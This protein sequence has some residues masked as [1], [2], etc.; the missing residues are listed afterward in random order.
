MNRIA[1]KG[2]GPLTA[3]IA[4]M[5]IAVDS[6]LLRGQRDGSEMVFEAPVPAGTEPVSG[7][8]GV[9]P[10]P[11][12]PQ[13]TNSTTGFAPQKK[14]MSG[15][16]G[17]A[18]AGGTVKTSVKQ[19]G[20][21]TAPRTPSTGRNATGI[22]QVSG[23]L[24]SPRTAIPGTEPKRLIPATTI[25]AAP[26]PTVPSAPPGM[27]SNSFVPSNQSGHVVPVQAT[28]GIGSGVM[29]AGNRDPLQV[30]TPD[31][32]DPA[33]RRNRREPAFQPIQMTPTDRGV[34]PPFRGSITGLNFGET[35]VERLIQMQTSMREMEQQ[36]DELRQLNAGLQ[37]RIKERE[38]QMLAAVRE[39]KVARKELALAKTDLERSKKELQNL[40]DRV[41]TAERE[42]AAV[43]RSMGPLLQQLLE[44]D[45][46]SSMPPNPAE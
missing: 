40:Q 25:N 34:Q 12:L 8:R 36:N 38:E 21:G 45:D 26:I 42:H 35:P 22:T 39:I 18:Q 29:T 17:V 7:Q 27:A 16:A 1:I 20:Y 32:M 30:V 33:L 2:L 19:T 5:L 3:F 37:N 13:R 46:V 11:T 44:S 15:P 41:R 43:L 23:T 31:G 4:V 10:L 24:S 9:Q 6:S 28:A 14:A